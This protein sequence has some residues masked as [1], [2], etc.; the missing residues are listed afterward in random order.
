[1]ATHLEAI[2]AGAQM[3]GVVNG[4]A[5]Q[6]Q[7]LFLQLSQDCV[8]IDRGNAG[9]DGCVAEGCGHGDRGQ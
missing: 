9:G 7:H 4:P 1:M 8:A 2:G 6:P 5:G 3:I